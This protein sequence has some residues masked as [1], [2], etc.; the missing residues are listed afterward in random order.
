MKTHTI[1]NKIHLFYLSENTHKVKTNP[2]ISLKTLVKIG[3]NC[4]VKTQMQYP[5]KIWLIHHSYI[6]PLESSIT[7]LWSIGLI[8]N[9]RQCFLNFEQDT[10]LL[11]FEIIGLKKMIRKKV[12]MNRNFL[13][14]SDWK[15]YPSNLFPQCDHQ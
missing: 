14:N 8:Y 6:K 13:K 7:Y 5:Q 15:P 3:S 4:G 12:Y 1:P 10:Y 11:C 9:L 2:T